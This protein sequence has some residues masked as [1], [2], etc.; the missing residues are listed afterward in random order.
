MV[1]AGGRLKV[2]YQVGVEVAQTAQLTMTAI[3]EDYRDSL[4]FELPVFRESTPETVATSGILSEAD[5]RTE[6]IELPDVYDPTQG[7]LTVSIDGSLAAGMQDGL[8]YLEHYPYECTEQTISRFLPN[9][10]TYQAY[11][12]LK[13]ENPELAEKLPGLVSIGRQRLYKHQHVDGGWG[14]WVDDDS[15]PMLTAY[16]LQA[17]I[18][19]QRAGFSVNK[20]F[21]KTGFDY[22]E[23]NLTAPKNIRTSWQANQQA[24]MLYVMAEGE[25]GDLGRSIA[26]FDNRD[27]LDIFGKAYL[28]MAIHLLDAKA[29]QLETLI[30]DISSAAVVSGTGAHWE[31]TSVDRWSMNTDTRSTAIVIG[32][33]SKIDP[34]NPLLPKAVRWL[35]TARSAGGYWRTTQETAWAIIGL[36]NWMVATGEL[37]ANYDWQV[38][39]NDN[40][41]GDGK[42]SSANVDESIKL[43]VD[44]AGL[45]AD[46]PNKLAIERT[47]GDKGNLYYGAYLTYYKPVAEVKAIDSGINVSRVYRLKGDKK[48]RPIFEAKVGDIIEVNLTI[49]IPTDRQYLI[50]EDHLP[51]GT[52]AIDTSLATT[53]VADNP[54]VSDDR[55]AFSHT[56]LRDEKAVLFAT[57][58]KK[59]SYNYTY[60]VRATVPGKYRVIPTHA[61]EM[62]FPEVFGR[63]EGMVFTVRE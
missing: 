53:S 42:F 17:L 3:G 54:D 59:G 37:D 48:N 55:Y 35:M 20:E 11:Q 51:A 2:E 4:T 6:A 44:V 8:D 25:V 13:L 52:E 15:N 50:I 24:F 27:K 14:W 43:R 21:L 56:E 46:A 1:A 7:D 61:E 39:L 47:G 19:A 36:T 16:V 41:I 5:T 31:E 18:E 38:M 34:K 40:Q 22:L 63:G 9:V 29:K 45:L 62:Y 33:L 26:L 30:N 12:S 58:L 23:T 28:A 10:V 57:Y 60:F 32:A 49:S